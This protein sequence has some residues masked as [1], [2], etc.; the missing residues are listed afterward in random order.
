MSNVRQ[1][2]DQSGES[3]YSLE[4]VDVVKDPKAALEE[5]VFFTP[6]L[7]RVFPLPKKKV[8]GSLQDKQK[9]LAAVKLLQTM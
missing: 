5:G 1:C 8:I 7:L 6:T 2:L 4:V 3:G 9:T